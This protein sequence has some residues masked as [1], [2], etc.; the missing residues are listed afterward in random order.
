MKEKTFFIAGMVAGLA[1]HEAGHL[2]VGEY[3]NEHLKWN[4]LEREWSIKTSSTGT[5]LRN[6]ALGGFA[7]Q[8][9]SSE[10]LLYSKA[11]KD[12][13]F[14]IGWL[15]WNIVEPLVY[16]ARHELGGGYGDLKLIDNYDQDRSLKVEHV[17][18]A[19]SAQALWTAYRLWKNEDFQKSP[20]RSYFKCSSNEV[21]AGLTWNF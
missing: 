13:S 9:V 12:N 1:N 4:I 14:V 21:E 20:L 8:I 18:I 17:E 3:Y 10:T 11:P 5:S 19:I 2:L 7:A 15:F 16:V 6:I